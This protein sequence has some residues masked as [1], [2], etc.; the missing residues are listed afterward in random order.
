[1]VVSFSAHDPETTTARMAMLSL[2]T[3]IHLNDLENAVCVAFETDS[4]IDVEGGGIVHL[5]EPVS[6]IPSGVRFIIS[7][8]HL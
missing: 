4:V 2:T 8:M 6:R 3:G 7:N 5:I 1:M